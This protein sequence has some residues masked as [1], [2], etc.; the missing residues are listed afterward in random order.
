MSNNDLYKLY[1]AEQG[2]EI[3]IEKPAEYS[4]EKCSEYAHTPYVGE[5][6]VTVDEFDGAAKNYLQ[7]DQTENL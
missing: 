2:I 4:N 1:Q 7:T 3:P 5:L 6:A